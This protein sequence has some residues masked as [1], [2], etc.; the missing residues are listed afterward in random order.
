MTFPKRYWHIPLTT[1]TIPW[2]G[3]R[4]LIGEW[5]PFEA[6]MPWPI[7]GPVWNWCWRTGFDWRKTQAE[8]RSKRGQHANR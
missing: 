2:W 6:W 8:E 1:K 4:A 7:K 5:F 3:W